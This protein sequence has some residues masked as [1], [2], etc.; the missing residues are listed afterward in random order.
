[1]DCHEVF[2]PDKLFRHRILQ[3]SSEKLP[4]EFDHIK[5][6]HWES[7]SYR[8]RIARCLKKGFFPHYHLLDEEIISILEKNGLKLSDRKLKPRTLITSDLNHNFYMGDEDHLRFEM[9]SS[10]LKN[11]VS[12]RKFFF[13]KFRFLFQPGLWAWKPRIGF[14]N[15][16]PTN[17]GRGD[18]LSVMARTP[19][20]DFMALLAMNLNQWGFGLEFSQIADANLGNEK[21]KDSVLVQF[22]IKNPNPN[23]KL[24]F[25][26]IL[27]LLGLG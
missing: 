19:T 14:I 20:K 6:I 21:K 25:F 3:I 4:E 15:A 23:Q 24:R 7:I 16:C 12:L 13:Y 2:L 10:N 8:L 27:S 18:R 22:S 1:M 11:F 5:K 9:I 17:C 26:K